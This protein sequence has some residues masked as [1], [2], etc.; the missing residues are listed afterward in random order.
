MTRT[1]IYTGSFDP[2]TNGH[3]DVI[4]RAAR[5]VDR[6]VVA[7][8][9]HHGKTPVFTVEQRL[10][11]IEAEVGDRVRGAGCDFVVTTFSGLAVD[12]ARDAG[13]SVIVRG[14]RDGTDF[15]YEIQMGTMNA[16]M[17]PDVETVFLAASPACRHIAASLVRQIANMGG[18]VSP[19][20]PATIAVALKDR[21][22]GQK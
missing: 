20:V 14:L 22:A 8:G 7:V 6:L 13:A 12:A 2:I 19:F 16:I 15:D 9:V 11:M 10:A 4:V 3:V 1:G 17:T 18:D 5:L 21:L